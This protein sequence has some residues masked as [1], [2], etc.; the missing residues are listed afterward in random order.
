M[1]HEVLENQTHINTSLE[2]FREVCKQM[3]SH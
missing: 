1:V 2:I 3:N